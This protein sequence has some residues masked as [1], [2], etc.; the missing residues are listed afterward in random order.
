M[1]VYNTG[2]LKKE[3]VIALHENGLKFGIYKTYKG[4]SILVKTKYEINK[5]ESLYL[6]QSD[7]LPY[8]VIEGKKITHGNLVFDSTIDDINMLDTK[9]WNNGNQI[10]S[11]E[12]YYLS[13]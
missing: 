10:I 5:R 1:I 8:K 2:Y 7:R 4:T 11:Y 3:A 12:D 9:D 13:N 6:P